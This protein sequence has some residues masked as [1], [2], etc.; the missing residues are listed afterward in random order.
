[1]PW[2]PELIATTWSSRNRNNSSTLRSGWRPRYDSS[3]KGIPGRRKGRAEGEGTSKRY[4][5]PAGFDDHTSDRK[6]ADPKCAQRGALSR[7]GLGRSMSW[8]SRLGQGDTDATKGCSDCKNASNTWHSFSWFGSR[9]PAAW[10]VGYQGSMLSSWLPSPCSPLAPCSVLTPPGT[11]TLHVCN[12]D[13]QG[14]ARPLGPAG[15]A[16]KGLCRRPVR[17][18]AGQAGNQERPRETCSQAQSVGTTLAFSSPSG[19]RRQAGSSVH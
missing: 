6:I 2:E 3:D 1:M 8:H 13:G 15:P 17:H 10:P 9:F 5:C 19:R 14:L 16:P 7:T 12:V 18:Q 11:P 4:V